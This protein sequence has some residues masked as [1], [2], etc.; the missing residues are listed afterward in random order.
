M[1]PRHSTAVEIQ[2]RA[3]EGERQQFEIARQLRAEFDL[4]ERRVLEAQ[5]QRMALEG[6][7]GPFWRMAYLVDIGLR[8][9]P[10]LRHL[11]VLPV[12]HLEITL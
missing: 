3:Q 2:L 8:A 1:R 9:R 10:A 7:F 6:L 5:M 11:T 12:H 4:I